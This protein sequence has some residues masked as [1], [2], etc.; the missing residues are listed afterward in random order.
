[1][2]SITK[3]VRPESLKKGIEKMRCRF[4]DVAGG[5]SEFI[6]R[7]MMF[8]QREPFIYFQ[9]S[10]CECIQAAEFLSDMSMHY[11]AEYYSLMPSCSSKGNSWPLPD[12][13]ATVAGGPVLKYMEIFR[14]PDED[15]DRIVTERVVDFYFSGTNLEW[16]WRILD[17]GAASGNFLRSLRKIGF[18]G[19]LMGVEPYLA[20]DRE[21]DDGITIQ[22]STI[23]EVDS[24]AQW[25]LIT[26][27]H[28]F[29]HLPNPLEALRAASKLLAKDGIC[30]IRTPIVPCYAW[31]HYGV[32]WIS[33]DAPRHYFIP[34]E[35]SI[36]ALAEK[37]GLRLKGVIYDSTSLQFWASEQYA[38]NI[39]LYSERSFA[40]NPLNSIISLARIPLLE[41]QAEELNRTKQ[42]DQAAFYLARQ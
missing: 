20:Q 38:Q 2:A 41:R 23:L 5:H 17:V 27:H 30:L 6:A 28:S 14:R 26:F 22:R 32:N 19:K 29:E 35:K 1:M 3:S 36:C 25:D 15:W 4:C 24:S 37:A 8:G 31:E 42:G 13:V 10:Q 21:S 9:C 7:E 39:P 16:D 12:W 34:S 18:T 33:L 11:P 40:I